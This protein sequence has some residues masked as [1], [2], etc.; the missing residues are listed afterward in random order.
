MLE[1]VANGVDERG[2]ACWWVTITSRQSWYCGRQQ[3]HDGCLLSPLACLET[4]DKLVSIGEAQ[5][6]WITIIAEVVA[7]AWHVHLSVPV[8]GDICHRRPL[9]PLVVAVCTSWRFSAHISGKKRPAHRTDFSPPGPDIMTSGTWWKMLWMRAPDDKTYRNTR[10]G[11]N[12]ASNLKEALRKPEWWMGMENSPL[13]SP[14]DSVE[15]A[16]TAIPNQFEKRP[17]FI[18]VQLL[19]PSAC[20][21]HF[22]PLQ[23]RNCSLSTDQACGGP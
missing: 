5:G 10:L 23:L 15:V 8:K 17:T 20:L 1:L 22:K 3:V 14:Y 13:R 21:L 12:S 19:W 16:T 7:T 2:G 11:G 9:G 18:L 4:I 6:L